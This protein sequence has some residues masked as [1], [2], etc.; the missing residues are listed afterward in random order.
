MLRALSLAALLLALGAGAA[1]A[2]V[3]GGTVV[4]FVALET[5]SQLVAV[6]LTERRVVARIPVP[7]GPRNVTAAGDLRQLLVTSPSTGKVALVDAYEGRVATVVGGVGRPLDVAVRG[8]RAFV[9]DA[10]RN[11]L[12]VL[13]LDRRRIAA[14]VRV[15]RRPQNVDVGDVAL[16]T[17]GVA[18]WYVTVVYPSRRGW[19]HA[20]L[21]RVPVPGPGALDVSRQPDSA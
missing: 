18:T 13:D 12:V 11:E 5:T 1:P 4:A 7:A 9:T 14:R 16:V 17:H 2:R 3:A 10:R 8:D 19:S 21:G 6:D 20:P 15:P